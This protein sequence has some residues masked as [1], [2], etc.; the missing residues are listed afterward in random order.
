MLVDAALVAC[1]AVHVRAHDWLDQHTTAIQHWLV[2][3]ITL[4]TS[5][6]RLHGHGMDRSLDRR[7]KRYIGIASFDCLSSTSGVCAGAL[8]H[9]HAQQGRMLI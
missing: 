1:M 6:A 5:N 3:L 4:Q 2:P 9:K 7:I 8:F